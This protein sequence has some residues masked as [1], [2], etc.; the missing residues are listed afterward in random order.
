MQ[1]IIL[2]CTCFRGKL[3]GKVDATLSSPS[4]WSEDPGSGAG[5]ECRVNCSSETHSDAVVLG[6]A[7]PR[8]AVFEWESD[9]SPSSLSES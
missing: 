7:V 5:A 6:V 1:L 8:V 9:E 4:E 3:L 2:I